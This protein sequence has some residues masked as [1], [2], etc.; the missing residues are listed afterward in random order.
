MGRSTPEYTYELKRRAFLLR[1]A[2]LSWTEV[3]LK[4]AEQTGGAIVPKQTLANWGASPE[5][6]AMIKTLKEQVAATV[7]DRSSSALPRVYDELEAAL[8]RGDARAVDA[9]SR[10]VVSL[11]KI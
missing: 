5:G 6:R 11:T 3:G 10:S 8:D 2:G 7:A 1:A 4:L 9:L